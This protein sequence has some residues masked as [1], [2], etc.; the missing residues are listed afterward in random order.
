M[1]TEILW[2]KKSVSACTFG[3]FCS[4]NSRTLNNASYQNIRHEVLLMLGYVLTRR[5]TNTQREC[6]KYQ[7]LRL[8][9]NTQLKKN[10]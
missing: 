5:T 6:C 2:S 8:S 1:G 10:A 3:V 7:P 9:N 4:V